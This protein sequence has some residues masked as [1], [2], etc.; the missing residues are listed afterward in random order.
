MT[1]AGRCHQRHISHRDSS[2]WCG[3]VGELGLKFGVHLMRGIPRK[4]VQLNLPIE[5]TSYHA[6]DIANRDPRT[7]CAWCTYN[8]GVD[9]SKPGAQAWYDSVV[10]HL[11]DM[12][13]ELIKYDDIVPYPAEVEAVA[14]AIAKTG[15]PI[16]LSLSPGNKVDPAAIASFRQANMLRVTGDIWDDAAGIEQCFAG[17]AQV[18]RKRTARLLDR[19]G[20]D[21]FR[22]VAA[23]DLARD[24]PVAGRIGSATGRRGRGALESAFRRPEADVH[25]DA[26]H[27]RLA[28]DDWRRLAHH[29]RI[30]ITSADRGGNDRLQSERRNGSAGE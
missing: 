7:N 22:P 23:N 16:V 15:K 24:R 17:M 5:G 21:P 10:R 8:Y 11:A 18:G 12:G 2:Y 3:A 4:A 19:Y 25:H 14:S 29:G 30:L 1:L 27:G 28:A 26:C 20:Y 6:A 9:M 13:V